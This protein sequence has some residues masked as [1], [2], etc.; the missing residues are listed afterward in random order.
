MTIMCK[1]LWKTI[2]IVVALAIVFGQVDMLQARSRIRCPSRRTARLYRAD[3]SLIARG[4]AILCEQGF[5]FHLFPTGPF[6]SRDID[7]RLILLNWSRVQHELQALFPRIPPRLLSLHFQMLNSNDRDQR[8]RIAFCCG[9]PRVV[10]LFVNILGVDRAVFDN[11]L[12]PVFETKTFEIGGFAN[13]FHSAMV[14][15]TLKV[16]QAFQWLLQPAKGNFASAMAKLGGQ[17][18]LLPPVYS[19]RECRLVSEWQEF[20][21]DVTKTYRLSWRVNVALVQESARAWNFVA[22]IDIGKRTSYQSYDQIRKFTDSR[23]L[24]NT[25]ILGLPFVTDATGVKTGNYTVGHNISTGAQRYESDPS[26]W[27]QEIQEMGNDLSWNG[28]LLLASGRQAFA[29]GLKSDKSQS[30]Q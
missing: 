29:D 11:D 21:Q 2:V 26:A 8:L 1:P 16:A 28:A 6:S 19:A 22:M 17:V 24:G 12:K 5:D 25:M 7:P 23:R 9:D 15:D 3:E 27:V 20:Y 30:P 10:N 18:A 13:E 4:R 14:P